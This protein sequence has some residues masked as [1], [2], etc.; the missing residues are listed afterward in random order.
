MIST[1]I[2]DLDGVIVNTAKYHYLAWKELADRLHID[3]DEK[4]NERLKGV[5]RIRSLE[6]ILELGNLTISE[7]DFNRY[8]EEKNKE[9]LRHIN[10][11]D[12]SEILPKVKETLSFLHR[13]GYKTSLGSASKN[14]R[15][16][17]EKIGLL[18]A[19]DAIVDGNE[20]T[21]GKPNPEVFLKG[22]EKTLTEP[23]NCVVFE[24]AVAGIK[25]ANRAGMLSVGIGSREVL[26]E[27]NYVFSSFEEINFEF[28]DQL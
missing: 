15:T 9:Y 20:V 8:M 16:I 18:N 5:S 27:A 1:F 14:A 17:L 25:A 4:N 7:E 19:F 13:K 10:Q 28:L 21:H 11:M 3:F 12:E 6:I 24:D 23:E 26:T 2:F 22:A